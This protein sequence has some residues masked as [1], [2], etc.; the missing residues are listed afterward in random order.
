MISTILFILFIIAVLI[1]CASDSCLAWVIAG[2]LGLGF[3]ITYGKLV[4][5]FVIELI[6][7]A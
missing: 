1:A 6:K 7:L 2:F 3:A 5:E 4:A